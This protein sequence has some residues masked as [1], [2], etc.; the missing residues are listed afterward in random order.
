AACAD[1]NSAGARCTRSLT[2]ACVVPRN[3]SRPHRRPS[4]PSP[5]RSATTIHLSSRTPSPSGSVGGLRNTGGKNSIAPSRRAATTTL[6]P[7][8]DSIAEDFEDLPALF[9]QERQARRANPFR[10]KAAFLHRQLDVLHEFRMRVQVQQG[11][12]PAIQLSRPA[13]FAPPC[14]FPE[15]L[16]F[17]RE[18]DPASRHPAVDP[19]NR[20]LEHQVIHSGENGVAISNRVV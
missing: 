12:E 2:C 18:S 20:A 11:R 16:V 4:R 13:P 19:Q 9:A 8:R 15:I 10:P 14:H 5:R 17:L 6:G 3:C 1:V 7:V